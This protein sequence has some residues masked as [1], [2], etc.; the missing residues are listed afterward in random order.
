M[1]EP[2][3]IDA[4]ILCGGLGKRLRRVLTGRPKPLALINGRPFLDILIGYVKEFGF[5]RFILCAGYK[6][7]V[8]E[9]YYDNFNAP[10]LSEIL[11]SREEKSLGT[12]G[13]LKNAESLIRSPVFLAMNGDS[14]CKVDLK[15]FIAFHSRKKARISL[16]LARIKDDSDYGKVSLGD[17]GMITG[18]SEKS[19]SA[20][21]GLVSAGIYLFQKSALSLIPV[22][23]KVSLEKDFFPRLVSKGIYG[24]ITGSALIDIGTPER[25]R[26][27][28]KLLNKKSGG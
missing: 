22:N 3:D 20:G 7:D 18:F 25:Y 2:M 4:V 23:R 6:A 10:S 13:A 5:R 8:L 17:S 24:Y 16:A 1:S 14:L 12:A 26:M 11:V 9:D 19:G 21:Y 15:K 28:Q 27:A